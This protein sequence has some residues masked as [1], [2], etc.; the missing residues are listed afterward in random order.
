MD[1]S[2]FQLTHRS[3]LKTFNSQRALQRTLVVPNYFQQ[4][5]KNASNFEILGDKNMRHMVTDKK[6]K[7]ITLIAE[8]SLKNMH[9]T[10]KHCRSN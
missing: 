4:I 6:N 3:T 7:K 5:I 2:Y 10:Q 8:N 1:Q 9:R